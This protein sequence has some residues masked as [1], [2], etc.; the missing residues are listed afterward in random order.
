[1]DGN[2]SLK[3]DQRTSSFSNVTTAVTARQKLS[4]SCE[5]TKTIDLP[6]PNWGACPPKRTLTEATASRGSPDRLNGLAYSS[7]F[8]EKDDE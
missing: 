2:S 1:M 8:S 4:K 3:E 5:H 6:S 7:R